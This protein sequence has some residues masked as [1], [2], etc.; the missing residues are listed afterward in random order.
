MIFN[1]HHP[2][3][4]HRH[5]H[6]HQH[7]HL[8]AGAANWQ[9]AARPFRNSIGPPLL[10]GLPSLCNTS[11]LSKTKLELQIKFE[12]IGLLFIS[13]WLSALWRS[14]SIVTWSLCISTFGDF[15][16][17][18]PAVF[19]CYNLVHRALVGGYHLIFASCAV[20]VIELFAGAVGGAQLAELAE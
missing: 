13:C 9:E 4:Y 2:P 6:P 3:L 14:S 18:K 8:R 15:V 5:F 16:Y 12:Q 19:I 20:A 10:C 17:S 7:H 11:E 1:N